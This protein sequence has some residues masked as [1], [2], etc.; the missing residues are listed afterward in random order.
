V[1]LRICHLAQLDL[2]ASWVMRAVMHVLLCLGNTA[3][4]LYFVH[5]FRRFRND[6]GVA[7]LAPLYYCKEF[8]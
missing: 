6:S 2:Q 4:Q 5:C 7:V 3:A 1:S 8:T